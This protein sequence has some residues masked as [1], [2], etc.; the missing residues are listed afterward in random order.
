M[1]GPRPA[2]A[3]VELLDRGEQRAGVERLREDAFERSA[4]G[5]RTRSRPASGAPGT[6]P[7]G[8]ASPRRGG[9]P[10]RGDRP[11]RRTGEPGRAAASPARAGRHRA[12]AARAE[13]L[14]EVVGQVHVVLDDHDEPVAPGVPSTRCSRCDR[15]GLRE[16]REQ[17]LAA[18]GEVVVADVRGHDNRGEAPD[19]ICRTRCTS[20]APPMSGMRMS[21]TRQSKRRRDAKLERLGAALGDGDL[22][23]EV[24]HGCRRCSPRRAGCRPR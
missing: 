18:G 2:A 24:A 21:L 5:R 20:S 8:A 23:A 12:E 3:L 10:A 9:R 4:A 14:G 13:R 16:H 7:P 19:R 15:D 11:A 6:S 22:S 1:S 17:P